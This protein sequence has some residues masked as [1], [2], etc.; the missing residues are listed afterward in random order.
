MNLKNE[1]L[2]N[3]K[4]GNLG[5]IPLKGT[6]MLPT[7]SDGDVL[8]VY[9]QHDYIVGDI[10]VFFYPGEGY[11][12]HRIIGMEKGAVLCKGDN[13]KRIEVIMKR[14]IVGKVVDHVSE[15]K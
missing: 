9:A 7:L 12:V 15:R 5:L 6:S 8:S 10:I 2:A 3:I 14:Q 11:L 13:S 1:I 4:R